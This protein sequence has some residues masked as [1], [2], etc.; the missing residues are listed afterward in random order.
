MIENE[1][2]IEKLVH[3]RLAALV[4]FAEQYNQN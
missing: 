4:L 1:A 3:T 2:R